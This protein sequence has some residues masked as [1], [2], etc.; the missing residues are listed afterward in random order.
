MCLTA[1]CISDRLA[2]CTGLS[3]PSSLPVVRTICERGQCC[4]P[5]AIDLL[6]RRGLAFFVFSAGAYSVFVIDVRRVP[7]QFVF[8]ALKH[9]VFHDHSGPRPLCNR[10]FAFRQPLFA[11]DGYPVEDNTVPW[12]ASHK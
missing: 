1:S 10:S 6:L 11:A 5:D 8:E 2:R 4:H 3:W 12:Y 7:V 9:V